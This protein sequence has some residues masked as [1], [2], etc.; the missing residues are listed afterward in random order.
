MPSARSRQEIQV[1]L[2]VILSVFVLV[3]GLLYLQEVRLHGT[4][5]ELVVRF[6][7]VGGLGVG[8]PVHVRGIP[9]GKVR[10]IDLRPDG[11]LVHCRI[12]GRVELREDA[13]WQLSS[14][15]LVGERIVALDPG[16]GEPM[17]VTPDTVFEGEYEL[18][19]AEMSGQL[20][21]LGE[22]FNDLLGRL[23]ATLQDIEDKGGVGDAVAEATR[24][25]RNLAE[26]LERNQRA[27][28]ATAQNTASITGKVD[29]F[30]DAHADSVGSV[31]DRMPAT[32]AKTDS[33]LER[34]DRVTADAEIVMAAISDT[35]GVVGKLILDEKLGDSVE[36]SILEV[37][38][39]VEDIRRNPQRY[40]HLTLVQ[41]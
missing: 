23:E 25:T 5:Q 19:M 1:G 40:L 34:L 11:V 13:R 17:V 35:T 30:L 10:R 8:D 20:S 16:Q 4:S 7:S 18:S 3:A 33:L 9:L 15:G 29:A 28:D 31:L 27:L 22:R 21:E 6:H 36:T 2:A 26:Y 37:Q 39:L 12:D 38:K 24:A 32:M 14:V 41:F